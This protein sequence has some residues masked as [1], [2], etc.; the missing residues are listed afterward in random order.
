MSALSADWSIIRLTSTIMMSLFTNYK[1][2][3][4]SCRGTPCIW[5][6]G[7]KAMSPIK[8][9]DICFRCAKGIFCGC[10]CVCTYR[11]N[12]GRCYAKHG[13]GHSYM[14]IPHPTPWNSLSDSGTHIP[15]FNFDG[16]PCLMS[17]IISPVDADTLEN[18]LIRYSCE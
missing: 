10:V 16:E 17:D 9:Q 8:G 6:S 13:I 14:Q 3:T 18:I 15:I 12:C 1:Q 4:M 2:G 5:S 11:H 7:E